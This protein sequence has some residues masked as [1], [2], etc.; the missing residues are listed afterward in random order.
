MTMR[1]NIGLFLFSPAHPFLFGIYFIFR[2]YSY[3]IHG[4]P[5]GE[6]LRPLL[7]SLFATCALMGIFHGP[8][9]DWQRSALMTSAALMMFFLYS[10]ATSGLIAAGIR[11]RAEILAGTWLLLAVLIVLRIAAGRG[12]TVKQ[13]SVAGINLAAVILLLFPAMQSLRY[14]VVKNI[15]FEADVDTAASIHITPLSPD[16]YYIILDGYG[17]TDA[18][19]PYGY[20]NRDFIESLR[21]MGFYVADC[22]Q[23]NYAGTS[24]SLTST[25]NMDYLQNLSSVFSPDETDLVNL[26]KLLEN[27]AVR[28][29]LTGAGYRSAAFASGFYWAEWR[30]AD[31]FLS[32]PRSSITEFET[33]ILFSTF[34]RVLDDTGALNL[35]D[36]HGENF[37][38]RTRLALGSFD[39]LA[40]MPGPKFV[41]VHIIAPHEPYVFDRHGNPIPPDQIN[42]REGYAN[43]TEFIGE[44]IL[45]GLQTLIR[46][47]TVPPVIILQ[48]DHGPSPRNPADRMK[49]LNAYHLPQG[50]DQLYPGI[51]PVNSFRIVFNSYF[52]TDYPLLEDVSYFSN[53]AGRYDFKIE[54][55]TCP[56]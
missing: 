26:Y 54:P 28:R 31:A 9:R 8:T 45:P 32:P 11:I 29:S 27:N 37:R 35:D 3:N 25:L 12:K 17:R 50:T 30:D 24:L 38:A 46:E 10:L 40:H 39:S 55:N 5:P 44:A 2:L 18:I 51:S 41:F 13:D 34:A 49:I 42:S 22:S 6:F 47:S 7:I 53:P 52:E 48:G 20:D 16:I 33:V 14:V 56:R 23:S 15:P 43:M 21:G 4:V 1:K 19:L 36:L